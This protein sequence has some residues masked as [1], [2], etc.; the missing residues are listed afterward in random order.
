MIF[1]TRLFKK[2]ICGL[3]IIVAGCRSD[4]IPPDYDLDGVLLYNEIHSNSTQGYFPDLT[5]F[6]PN[7][8]ERFL[9]TREKL[10]NVQPSWVAGGDE[11]IFESKRVRDHGSPSHLYLLNTR[12]S[13]ITPV[14]DGMDLNR[15]TGSGLSN[16][17]PAVNNQN[18]RVYYYRQ[19]CSCIASTGLD[20]NSV[21]ELE[22]KIGTPLRIRW[23]NDYDYLLVH[24]MQGRGF[25]TRTKFEVYESDT[26]SSVLS[27]DSLGRSF[28]PGDIFNGKLLYAAHKTEVDSI[29][30]LYL[31]DLETGDIY[32]I[33]NHD[34]GANQ[35][36]NFVNPIFKD[37]KS[38][39]YLKE[40]TPNKYEIFEMDILSGEMSQVTFDNTVKGNL[41]IYRE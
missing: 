8:G 26:Y 1:K 9:L 22:I 34:R 15:I 17:S 33:A 16:R 5:A 30:S 4:K 11:I 29:I 24:E 7:T 21:M 23:S 10:F 2:L 25:N 37:E 40:V 6:N 31:L 18:N 35:L 27:S 28:L 12:T 14:H 20:D 39:Y 36:R 41:T 19:E 3:L 32:E 13:R 38:I